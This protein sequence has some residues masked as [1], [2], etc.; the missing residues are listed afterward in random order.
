MPCMAV[1]M[2]SALQIHSFHIQPIK[3]SEHSDSDFAHALLVT[4]W[5]G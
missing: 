1:I 5:K 4:L 3:P 2:I